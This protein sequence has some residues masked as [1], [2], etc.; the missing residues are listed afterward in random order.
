MPN[1][2]ERPLP[3]ASRTR[4]LRPAARVRPVPYEDTAL[5]ATAT[6]NNWIGWVL[7]ADNHAAQ[8]ATIT[9]TSAHSLY[10]ASNLGVLPVSAAWRSTGTA[11]QNLNFDLGVAHAIDIAGIVNHNLSSSATI[12]LNAGTTSAVSDFTTTVT[13]RGR[14]A[15]R[16]LSSP[17]NYRYWQVQI[18]DSGNADGFFEVG[19]AVVAVLRKPSFTFRQGWITTP[20]YA[21]SRVLSEFGTPHIEEIYERQQLNLQFGPLDDNQV[22]VLRQAYVDSKRNLYPLLLLPTRGGTD[23]YFGRIQNAFEQQTAFRHYAGIEFVEDSFGQ[24]LS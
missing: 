12:T 8:V 2:R 20:E 6:D 13:W 23:A 1:R 4:P 14:T 21:V 17:E 3:S 9:A 7:H 10:P 5:A 19:Y 15:F 18:A 22:S 24:I 11:T 16:W